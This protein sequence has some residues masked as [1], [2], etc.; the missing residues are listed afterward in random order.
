VNF[1]DHAAHFALLDVGK[2][3]LRRRL[4]AQA[5]I[6]RVRAD[7]DDL[8]PACRQF[9]AMPIHVVDAGR[10]ALPDRILIGEAAPGQALVDNSHRGRA[11]RVLLAKRAAGDDGNAERVKEVDADGVVVFFLMLILVVAHPLR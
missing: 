4:V 11:G 2:K 9:G 6:A 1:V 3:E 10:E 8:D 7:A 5:R